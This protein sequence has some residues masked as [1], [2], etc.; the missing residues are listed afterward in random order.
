M[1]E[2]KETRETLETSRPEPLA[3][4]RLSREG[5]RRMQG[6]GETDRVAEALSP[7]EKQRLSAVAQ[8]AMDKGPV[9]DS[10]I[11]YRRYASEAAAGANMPGAVSLDA[12]TEGFQ[13][14]NYP[15]YDLASPT[16]VASVKT[17]WTSEGN[18]DTNALNAYVRDFERQLGWG[19]AAG[20][21][22]RDGERLVQVRDQC[23]IP[24]PE[25]L[26]QANAEAAAEYLRLNSCLRIPEDHVKPVQDEL[27][28]RARQ[29][30]E[31]YGLPVDYTDADLTHLRDRVRSLGL[32]SSD[33][34]ALIQAQ[35][36][37][38]SLAM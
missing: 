38:R 26:K 24:V 35:M 36:A 2:L 33:L 12:A 5:Q 16:E 4:P 34:R 3:T 22:A 11:H 7:A 27:V 17:H 37:R 6:K 1:R 31:T 21:V 25:A 8:E 20:S 23:G 18:L 9:Q 32:T 29:S 30:P 28:R 13:G 14:H 15:L 10:S 19:R